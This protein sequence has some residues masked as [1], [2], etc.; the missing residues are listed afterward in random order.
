MSS[1]ANNTQAVAED[2]CV[3]PEQAHQPLRLCVQ[4]ALETYFQHLDGQPPHDLYQFV[5]AEVE[6]PLLE[7]TL[8]YSAGNQS[9]AAEL[10]GM[11]RGTLRKKLRYYGIDKA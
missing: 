9:R 8:R 2:H 7:V 1:R 10:L 11:N 3:A 4:Q 6:P 5:M